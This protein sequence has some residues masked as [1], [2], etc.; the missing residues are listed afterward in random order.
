MT[1]MMSIRAPRRMWREVAVSLGAVLGVACIVLAVMSGVFGVKPL[2]FTSGSMSPE[3]RT[4]A[5]AFAQETAAAD[6]KVGDVVSVSDEAGVR[7]THRVVDTAPATGATP[8]GTIALTLKGD[9]NQSPDAQTYEVATADRVLLDVPYAGH[10]AT[11][12]TSPVGLVAGGLLLGIVMLAAFSPSQGPRHLRST[13]RR[14][15]LRTVVALSVIGVST[16]ATLQFATTQAFWTDSAGATSG[17]FATVASVPAPGT[18]SCVDNGTN[19]TGSWGTTGARYQY[20]VTVNRVDNGDQVGSAQYFTSTSATLNPTSFATTAAF[21]ATG[22]FN[23]EFRV[24]SAALNTTTWLSSASARIPFRFNKAR[25]AITCG[26]ITSTTIRIDSL[27]DD[28]GASRTDFV[29]RNPTNSLSGSTPAGS[30]ST[31]VI[32]REGA[33]VGTAEADP[34]TGAWTFAITPSVKERSQVYTAE[35]TDYLGNIAVASQV[36]LL[37]TVAPTAAQTTSACNT[38]NA[39]AGLSNVFWCRVTSLTMTATY[40]DE[41]G[42]SGLAT[43]EYSNSSSSFTPYNAPVVLGEGDGRVVQVRATDLAGNNSTG[44]RTYYIDGTAPEL[45]FTAP[46]PAAD[47]GTADNL[48]TAVAACGPN[49]LACGT[50]KDSVSGLSSVVPQWNLRREIVGV[51]GTTAR[52]LNSGTYTS[53]C[54]TTYASIASGTTFSISSNEA[55]ASSVYV[56]KPILA[57]NQV[58]TLTVTQVADA[59]GNSAT[60]TSSFRG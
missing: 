39:V 31:I 41:A 15:T 12:L 58:Y 56:S 33:Q 20:Q 55:A 14:S 21:Q 2:V 6:L 43:K 40:T 25:T 46:V 42:G 11:W 48:R 44:S 24:K 5:L 8:D 35:A 30:A 29:T 49:R 10:A 32:K 19:V 23:F 52:C 37:D 34:S 9:A 54:S 27:A 53:V 1:S 36:V 4:G 22:K 51:L 3:I 59:A 60:V 13:A 47:Y 26:N 17:A 28:S 18:A 16:Q 7:I 57:L 45:K 38:G 50:L